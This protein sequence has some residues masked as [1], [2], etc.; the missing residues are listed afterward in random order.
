MLRPSPSLKV[1]FAVAPVDLRCGHDEL[2]AAVRAQLGHDPYA[3]HLFVFFGRSADRVK[4][5]FWDRGGFV[6]YDKRLERGRFRLPQVAEGA[7]EVE[8]DAAALAMLLD[9][10]D[11]RHVRRPSPG[12]PPAV[13]RRAS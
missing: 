7:T 5:L 4:I 9:G 12:E 10:I 13:E 1:F 2:C 8:L 3:G 11:L 6:V